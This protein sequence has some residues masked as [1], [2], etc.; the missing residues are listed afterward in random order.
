MKK[1]PSHTVD[2]IKRLFSEYEMG[3]PSAM[4]LAGLHDEIARLERKWRIQL[5]EASERRKPKDLEKLDAWYERMG[6]L[7]EAAIRRGSHQSDELSL[8]KQTLQK[9]HERRS[10]ST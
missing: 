7:I 10:T 1:R 9:T 8:L 5:E 4:E 6:R 2:I 3:T